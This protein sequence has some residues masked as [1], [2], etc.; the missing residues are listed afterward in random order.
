MSEFSIA[1]GKSHVAELVQQAEGGQAV[2]VTRTRR[3]VAVLISG[4]AYERLST[5]HDSLLDFA[6]RGQLEAAAA[7]VLLPE[8]PQLENLRDHSDRSTQTDRTNVIVS[9]RVLP[10]ALIHLLD[11]NVVS[12][13][14]KQQPN[15]SVV[16]AFQRHES[17]FAIGATTAAELAFG[18]AR[19]KPGPPQAQIRRWLEGLL[20]RLP[21]L[22]FDTRAALWPGQERA[23]L[24]GEGR[25]PSR[26]D[27]EIAAVALTNGLTLVTKN[28]RHFASF[29]ACRRRIGSSRPFLADRRL[30]CL[31]KSLDALHQTKQHLRRSLHP[32]LEGS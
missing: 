29:G 5:P 8:N 10:L 2:R 30:P 4:E 17:S 6:S 16:L 22:P 32:G 19:M 12:E 26:T 20:V 31:L 3:P 18:C 28:L 21:V 9:T 7:G 23:R 13:L 14:T 11:T 27:G 1:R 15:R 24:V 25:P